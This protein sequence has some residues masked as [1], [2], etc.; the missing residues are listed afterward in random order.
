M[1]GRVPKRLEVGETREWDRDGMRRRGDESGKMRHGDD[2]AKVT[3]NEF[4][5][6]YTRRSG[7]TIDSRW[8]RRGE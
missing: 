5:D 6:Y 2:A 4:I 1:I 3:K 7:K 8:R